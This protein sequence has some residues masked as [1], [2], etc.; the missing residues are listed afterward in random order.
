[1]TTTVSQDIIAWSN[2]LS[3]WKQD[4][5]RRLALSGKINDSDKDELI[6]QIRTEV[7]LP[8]KL[9]TVTTSVPLLSS[10]ISS[11]TIQGAIA[12]KAITDVQSVNQLTPAAEL[13]FQ[14]HGLTVIYGTNGSGK[15]GFVRIFRSACRSR[16]QDTKKLK[17]LSDVYGTSSAPQ[18]A[19]IVI[20]SNNTD[21]TIQWSETSV[22]ESSLQQVAV[23]D[24]QSAQIY[25]DAGNQIQFLPLGLDLP[26][27]FNSLCIAL[28]D[29]LKTD[30]DGVSM[31]LSIES[32]SFSEVRETVSQKF[33]NEL[34]EKTTD[35]EI[36]AA[37]SAK[38]ADKAQLKTL[39]E[40]MA[41]AENA[42]KVQKAISVKVTTWANDSKRL[43]DALNDTEV[44]AIIT[45]IKKAKS[46]REAAT[47]SAQ[48]DLS[49]E[50]LKGVGSETWRAL[51]EAAK[52]YSI[53][54]AY[55]GKE[56]PVLQIGDN[57]A[58]CVLCQQELEIEATK[59]MSRF[60]KF[61]DSTL[62]TAAVESE[63][64]L[65]ERL[66]KLPT[67][68]SF[69]AADFNERLEGVDEDV[70]TKLKSFIDFSQ[71]RLMAIKEALK[72][73]NP[74]LLSKDTLPKITNLEP[75][76]QALSK[77]AQERAKELEGT[78]DPEQ[79]VKL[80]KKCNELSD[81]IQ[82][83]DNKDSLIKRRDLLK[84]QKSYDDAMATLKTT[85]TT[86]KATELIDKHVTES[87]IA[88]F[89]QEQKS[90]NV[91]HLKIS[92]AKKT[93][94]RNAEFK[95]D[96]GTTLTKKTSEILSEGE[97]RA[98]ALAAFFTE[99][100][101]TIGNGPIVID[102]PVSSLDRERG[103]LVANRIIKEAESRQVIIFT[104]DIIFCN[105]L[106]ASAHTKSV[107]VTGHSI[108]R[109]N[110]H[111]GK[112]DPNGFPWK[113]LAVNKRVGKMKDKL[114]K[115]KKITT[116]SPSEWEPIARSLYGN[117]RDTYERMV[118]EDIFYKV[119]QRGVDAVQTQRLRRVKLSDECAITFH[120]NMTKISAYCHDNPES[121]SVPVPTPENFQEDL[122]AFESLRAK[123]LSEASATEAARPSMKT[124][125]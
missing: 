85:S 105:Q 10:H 93:S 44:E 25:I 47:I 49:K 48:S 35:D 45:A 96:P 68:G 64:T 29:K 56:F 12:I 108:F 88:C 120:E 31:R 87:V 9:S 38:D 33:Y 92:L 43:W 78:T 76:L 119:V 82:L 23:F 118:E 60:N 62:E 104:H 59:R 28:K 34:S 4:A 113:G 103:K 2:T 123:I 17:I 26:L 27:R 106:Y 15:S 73:K 42:V 89:E 57:K 117:L 20:E 71:K 6:D 94:N 116:T 101:I 79:K 46:T 91:D 21:E 70:A 58:N 55:L 50:P 19:K 95:T 54:E 109:D 13:T 41:S 107:D 39:S 80:L 99:I 75:D 100:E 110:S 3:T 5:L 16:I 18:S 98:L 8:I 84:A 74:E 112:V 14:P 83:T 124:M 111:S 63:N 67:M 22:T 1:M 90:L 81:L 86:K 66:L 122:T 97:Q 40:G 102:D 125:P 114:S 72:N 121:G 53:N 51:W 24:S 115:T 11:A 36:E 61:M 77:S 52:K 69:V 37:C 65:S 7:G 30:A 32:I